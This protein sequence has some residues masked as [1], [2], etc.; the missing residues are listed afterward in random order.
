[1]RL[2]RHPHPAMGP[3]AAGRVAGAGA[4]AAARRDAVVVAE[5]AAAAPEAARPGEMVRLPEAAAL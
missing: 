5:R 3:G 2:G 1:M 4:V